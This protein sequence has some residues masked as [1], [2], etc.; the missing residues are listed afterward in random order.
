MLTFVAYSLRILKMKINKLI[1]STTLGDRKHGL[2]APA[3]F[4]RRRPEL[5][6]A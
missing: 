6:R 5:P 2:S 4:N 1:L 3:F